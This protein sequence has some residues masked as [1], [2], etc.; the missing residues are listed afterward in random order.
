MAHT[1]YEN[2]VL[3][4]KITDLLNTKL[5]VRSFMTIDTSLTEQSGMIKRIHT[6]TY[7]GKVEK[8]G[9]GAK[10]TTRGAVTFTP[11]DYE[12]KLAQQVF[13]Y[14]DE[15]VMQDP[16]VVDV[17]MDGSAVVMVN[18]LNTEYFAELKKATLVHEYT[19]TL[20]YDDTV[21][22]ISLLNIESEE[23]LFQIIGTG[24]KAEVRKDPDF[25]AAQLG[26]IL[27]NGQIGSISGVPVIVS[28]LC[29]ENTAYLATK[30]AV[31]CFIKKD[32]EVEQDRDAEARKNTVILR[33]VNLV[34]LTN[35]T[36][37]VKLTKKA[38]GSA[39]VGEGKVGE[40][41]VGKE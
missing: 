24:L 32:S 8:L 15:E 21:D 11:K 17:A 29:E 18:D 25:K 39:A 12:V 23:G 33:K 37:V 28:K 13:D 16:M 20:K 10:N 41:K 5:A 6:Y 40:A 2:F 36:K 31:T 30:E 22:A 14:H 9:L 34:A 35:A 7:A 27:F 19:G 26:Q 1:L 4:N 38:V 3:E